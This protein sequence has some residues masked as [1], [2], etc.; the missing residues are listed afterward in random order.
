MM[1]ERMSGCFSDVTIVHCDMLWSR[2]TVTETSL[3]G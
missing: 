3:S 2:D 1:V